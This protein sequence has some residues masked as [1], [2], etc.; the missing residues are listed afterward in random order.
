MVS[1]HLCE[2][3]CSPPSITA[4]ISAAKAFLWVC[5]SRSFL[6]IL[7]YVIYAKKSISIC[8]ISL[9]SITQKLQLYFVS[10]NIL[11]YPIQGQSAYRRLECSQTVES[12]FVHVINPFFFNPNPTMEKTLIMQSAHKIDTKKYKSTKTGQQI[13]PPI[14][15]P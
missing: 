1:C 7:E 3:P 4:C 12:W 11:L 5:F 15:I 10:G 8:I 6:L 9:F 13:D 2:P 14:I